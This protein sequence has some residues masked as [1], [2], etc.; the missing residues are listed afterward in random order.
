MTNH[1]GRPGTDS[2][3]TE[4]PPMAPARILRLDGRVDDD[5]SDS[6]TVEDRLAMVDAL[7]KRMWEITGRPLPSY[8]RAEIP[9]KIIHLNDR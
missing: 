3:P 8:A 5:L 1:Q 2:S 4:T 7:S 9:A 6:T